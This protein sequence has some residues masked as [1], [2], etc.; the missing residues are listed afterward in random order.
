MCENSCYSDLRYSV[1]KFEIRTLAHR[2][3]LYLLFSYQKSCVKI[4]ATTA[5]LIFVSFQ[6][7]NC[8]LNIK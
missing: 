2:T 8:T 1:F 5:L 6:E 3:P 7:E 4:T